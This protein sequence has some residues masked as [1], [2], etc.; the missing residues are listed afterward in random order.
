MNNKAGYTLFEVL[1]AFAI[2]AM[3]LAVLLPR[4]TLLLQRTVGMQ[5]K[6]L[7]QELALSELARMGGEVPLT[8]G[9]DT[10]SY[11]PWQVRRTISES[12]RIDA[13]QTY[14]IKIEIFDP[15]DKQLAGLAVVKVSP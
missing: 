6:A 10:W 12:D 15:S 3:V 14:T 13:R 2:M 4:Q 9:L 1:V 7:A 11:G 8:S 5:D